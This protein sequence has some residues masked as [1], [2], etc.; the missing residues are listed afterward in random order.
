MTL[1]EK[2]PSCQC[3][4]L[5]GLWEN[6]KSSSI[7]AKNLRRIEKYSTVS[8]KQHMYMSKVLSSV[9]AGTSASSSSQ[10]A[11]QLSSD[12]QNTGKE[13]MTLFSRAVIQAGNFSN[14]INT[15]NQSPMLATNPSS[16]KVVRWKRLKPLNWKVTLTITKYGLIF[17]ILRILLAWLPLITDIWPYWY[18][19]NTVSVVNFISFH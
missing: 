1:E 17:M 6:Q 11:C 13:S 4:Q 10:S 7:Q 14:H 3:N 15:I 2:G 19:M 12:S 8:M 18:M 9:V 16:S 5:L